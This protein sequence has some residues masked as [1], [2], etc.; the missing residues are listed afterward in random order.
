MGFF[1]TMIAHKETASLLYDEQPLDHTRIHTH[2]LWKLKKKEETIWS[3]IHHK[4]N[5]LYQT[6]M[7]DM[8]NYEK[9]VK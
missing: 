8:I 3:R 4:F 5:I 9:S 2:N 6:I 7:Y 1:P